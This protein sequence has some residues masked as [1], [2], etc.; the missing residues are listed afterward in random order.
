MSS[1]SYII[2]I[3]SYKRHDILLTKSL[4][5]LISGGV[6]ASKIYI[7]VANKEEHEIYEKNIPKEMYHDLVIGVK[8]ITNQRRFI[9]NY[10]PEGQEIVS[11]DDDVEG[12]YKSKGTTKLV[13]VKNID[14]FYKEA[15]ERLHKEHLYI[16]GIYPVRNPF[17]MKDTVTT[18]LKF[19]IGTMYGFINR[20]NP[21]LQPSKKI[22]EKEDY[23]Q[24]ILYYMMD[25]GVL[26][27]NNIT[28]K[29]KFHAEGGLGK[30]D[31]RFEANK[32]AAEY[33][34][35]KYPEYV[36]VFHRANGMSEVRLR[37][38]TNKNGKTEKSKNNKTHKNNKTRKNN[39]TE[40]NV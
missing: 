35:K 19:I 11:I 23:E 22:K 40:K 31:Q 16:W 13:Q 37:D 36:S 7:F 20:H 34:E 15:F 27:Y 21:K 6:P 18:N 29:T 24:S 8:G 5:T 25:G 17:F 26:R 1:K 33:L 10:F 4:K 30:I 38:S 14:K 9:L 12:L 3:P 28:I 39:K 32:E 2:A